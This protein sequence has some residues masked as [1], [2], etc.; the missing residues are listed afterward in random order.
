MWL[1]SPTAWPLKES[2]T[3]PD[4]NLGRPFVS[5]T[6]NERTSCSKSVKDV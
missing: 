1:T 2:V 4:L 6:S 5:S 3:N